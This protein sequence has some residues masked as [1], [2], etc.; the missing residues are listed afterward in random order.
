MRV[1]LNCKHL[2][3]ESKYAD[4]IQVVMD[5]SEGTSGLRET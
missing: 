2:E 3:D 5:N 1:I 4:D